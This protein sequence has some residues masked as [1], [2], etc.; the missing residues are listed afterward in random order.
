MSIRILLAEDQRIVRECICT[1]LEQQADIEVIA[2]ADDGRKVLDLV[3]ERPPDIIIM[4]ITMPNLNGIEATR[5]IVAKNPDIK[6]VALSMHSNKR[7]IM[8]MLSA[9]ASGYL[10]KDCVFEELIQ[11]IHAVYAG[12]NYLSNGIVNTLVKGYFNKAKDI[13]SSTL[14]ILTC[15]EREVL[16][17]LAEGKTVREIAH[18]LYLSMKT[19]ETYRQQIM[20]KL[21]IHSVAE[22]TKYAIRE[23]LTSLEL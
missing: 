4:D 14:R 15:R 7:F 1:L 2:E 12:R 3:Q 19:I 23:G 11:A 5:Q 13:D 18:H 22:L 8:E 21:E 9:G 20:N 17:L 16:Q 6:I 10:L